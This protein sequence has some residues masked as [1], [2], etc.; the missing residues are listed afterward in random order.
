MTRKRGDDRDWAGS[1]G[2]AVGGGGRR[3]VVGAAA[4]GEVRLTER[5][6][7]APGSGS[8]QTNGDF[9][10]AHKGPGQ[11]PRSLNHSPEPSPPGPATVQLYFS[12]WTL[13]PA[14]EKKKA[15]S[16]I[17]EERTG[18]LSSKGVKLVLPSWQYQSPY[19][20]HPALPRQVPARGL[21]SGPGLSCNL[22]LPLALGTFWH[23]HAELKNPWYDK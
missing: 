14:C 11:P 17:Q 13:P 15:I 10:L 5:G 21:T 1:G 19:P 23:G 8:E 2:W 3:G 20:P 4:E 12:S 6:S 22:S 16:C 18:A 7:S 9:C